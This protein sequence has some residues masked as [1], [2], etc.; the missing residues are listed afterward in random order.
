MI[1]TISPDQHADD[2]SRS[3]ADYEEWAQAEG[4]F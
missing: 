1:G 2:I 3:L 4:D